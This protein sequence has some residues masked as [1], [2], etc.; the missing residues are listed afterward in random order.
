MGD[1]VEIVLRVLLKIL[2]NYY[3]EILIGLCLVIFVFLVIVKIKSK[4]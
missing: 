4:S 3:P 2:G 1:L